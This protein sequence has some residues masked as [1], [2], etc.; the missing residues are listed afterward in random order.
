MRQKQEAVLSF[1]SDD[2]GLPKVVCEYRA[3]YRTIIGL[4]LGVV[5][6]RESSG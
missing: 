3:R 2:K 1:A 5:H 6:F 4:S